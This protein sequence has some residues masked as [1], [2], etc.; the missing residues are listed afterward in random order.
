[1]NISPPAP[2]LLLHSSFLPTPSPLLLTSPFH[3]PC[4]STSPA[5]IASNILWSIFR[6][7]SFIDPGGFSA[8]LKN[9]LPIRW[10]LHRWQNLY[11]GIHYEKHNETPGWHSTSSSL[12]ILTCYVNEL[13]RI[14]DQSGKKLEQV[15]PWQARPRG[16]SQTSLSCWAHTAHPKAKREDQKGTLW[17]VRW[18]LSFLLSCSGLSNSAGQR[19]D[20]GVGVL[21]CFAFACVFVCFCFAFGIIA[22]NL[23]A[24]WHH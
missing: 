2:G 10:Y 24:L 15:P 11:L 18:A 12:L 7:S 19:E 1:M 8:P 20:S 17:K 3:I 5:T 16:C 21:V 9:F 23:W 6:A 4:F 13:I 14:N 22:Q